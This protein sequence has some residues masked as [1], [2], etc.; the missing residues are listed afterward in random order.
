MLLEQMSHAR[1]AALE[2]NGPWGEQPAFALEG[3]LSS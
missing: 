2:W 3:L 1:L